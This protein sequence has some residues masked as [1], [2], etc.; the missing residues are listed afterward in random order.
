[1]QLVN[2]LFSSCLFLNLCV[3]SPLDQ[4]IEDKGTQGAIEKRDPRGGHWAKRT[5]AVEEADAVEKRDPVGGYWTKWDLVAEE[6][7][8]EK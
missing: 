5:L 7:D 8:A 4:A 3:G 6:D 2:L 1:M